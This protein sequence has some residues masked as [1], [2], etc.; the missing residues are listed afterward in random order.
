MR[1][2]LIERVKYT[3]ML[4]ITTIGEFTI[5]D[6]EDVQDVV[7]E[8]TKA[9]LYHKNHDLYEWCVDAESLID[10]INGVNINDDYSIKKIIEFIKQNNLRMF[11][12]YSNDKGLYKGYPYGMGV[13]GFVQ[14][15]GWGLINVHE[16][17]DST[18]DKLY[19]LEREVK[20]LREE[21]GE[22]KELILQSKGESKKSLK[23]SLSY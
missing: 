11:I 3:N 6:C 21:I 13:Y 1:K 2:F 15:F 10:L 19:R 16:C 20:A 23:M 14:T 18:D 12:Q 17:E 4:D 5:D 7:L 9:I 8:K 22:L